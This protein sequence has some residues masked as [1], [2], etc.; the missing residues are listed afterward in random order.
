M[1]ILKMMGMHIEIRGTERKSIITTCTQCNKDLDYSFLA[2]FCKSPIQTHQIF[3]QPY[4]HFF[5]NL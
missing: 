4:L 3:P 1:I 2:F 5:T